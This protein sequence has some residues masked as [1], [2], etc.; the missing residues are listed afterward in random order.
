[1]H[2]D[3]LE[4]QRRAVAPRL[5]LLVERPQGLEISGVISINRLCARALAL[6]ERERRPDHHL[7]RLPEGNHSIAQRP[8]ACPREH[9][10][11]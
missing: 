8:R 5:V 2:L 11:G 4:N 3:L 6:G 7:K 10:L 1:M 9:P